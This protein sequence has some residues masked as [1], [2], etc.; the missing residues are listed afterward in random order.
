[1]RAEPHP[2]PRRR[3]DARGAS[4][5][6]RP[7]QAIRAARK[8]ALPP[9]HRRVVRPARHC[10]RTRIRSGPR[11]ADHMG[12]NAAAA[13]P[14]PLGPSLRG[15]APR[16]V[17]HAR[18]IPQAH[19]D[20][21]RGRSRPPTRYTEARL[22]RQLK[23]LDIGRPSTCASIVGVLRERGSA[24]PYRRRFAPTERGRAVTAFLETWFARCAADGSTTQREAQ[25][26]SERQD[27][28]RRGMA[29]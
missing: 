17:P 8:G 22:V 11:E 29:A 21:R 28:L 23:A 14:L 10:A 27:Y 25:R 9:R 19:P 2:S 1:M 16:A 24:V 15:D 20:A 5:R 3:D 12:D 13:Q 7:S 18:G 26:Q 4:H 6:P